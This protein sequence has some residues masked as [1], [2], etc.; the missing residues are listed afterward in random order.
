MK[1][2]LWIS[3]AALLLVPGVWALPTVTITGRTGP[4]TLSGGPFNA[5][6]SAHGTFTTWCIEAGEFISF[7]TTY[8]YTIEDYAVKGGVLS[9]QDPISKATAWLFLNYSSI[10]GYNNSSSANDAVQQAFWYLEG[11]SGGVN[12]TYAQTAVTAAGTGDNNGFYPVKVM[13]LWANANGTGEKQSMLIRV[14]DGGLTIVLLG[15]GMVGLA[16][17]RRKV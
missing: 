11:E 9:G 4:T 6:T 8:Y 3:L 13:N 1:N 10:L 17:W 7:N 2:K 16:A 5:V 14:P 15:L 12:N